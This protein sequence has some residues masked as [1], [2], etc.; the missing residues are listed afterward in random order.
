MSTLVTKPAPDFT[1][2]AVLADNTIDE[3]F[4]LNSM[5]GKYVILFFY[6]LDFTFVC[7][8]EILAFDRALDEFKIEGVRTTIGFHRRIL[9]N[10]KFIKG[11]IH[12]HFIEE[13]LNI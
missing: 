8:S 5:R 1:A 2:N 13:E 4:T 3:K 7:P 9:S 10:K 12:T 11:D 6:P